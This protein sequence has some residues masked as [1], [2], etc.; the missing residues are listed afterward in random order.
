MP[1]QPTS[2]LINRISDIVFLIGGVHPPL[3]AGESTVGA[4]GDKCEGIPYNEFENRG[5]QHEHTTHSIPY[6]TG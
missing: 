1:G 6:A 5:Y 4:K 3:E 2:H